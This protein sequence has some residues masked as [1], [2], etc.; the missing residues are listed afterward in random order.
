MVA[1]W[2]VITTRVFEYCARIVY[3]VLK[4]LK[5]K[6]AQLGLKRRNQTETPLPL[7]HN[8]RVNLHMEKLPIHRRTFSTFSSN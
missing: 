3:V 6:L 7:L 8:A 2:L 5:Q 1:V 4:W